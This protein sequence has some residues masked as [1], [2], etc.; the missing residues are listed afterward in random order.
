MEGKL[1]Q[2]EEKVPL[3]KAEIKGVFG[4]GKKKVAGTYVPPSRHC[5]VLCCHLRLDNI[6]CAAQGACLRVLMQISL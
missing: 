4:S 5:A 1:K 2:I 6:E 3:G